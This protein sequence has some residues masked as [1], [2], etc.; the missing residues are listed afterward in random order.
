MLLINWYTS[1][2]CVF[3]VWLCFQNCIVLYQ[4]MEDPLQSAC[5][6]AQTNNVLDWSFHVAGGTFLCCALF[7]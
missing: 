6:S 3:N 2:V 4:E 5:V 7:I 1:H